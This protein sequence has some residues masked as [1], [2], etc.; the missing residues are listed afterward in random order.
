M[1]N[2]VTAISPFR[3]TTYN[4][5][6]PR[7][8]SIAVKPQILVFISWDTPKTTRILITALL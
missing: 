7:L 5:G 6:N 2:L 1:S 4:D 3:N 8:L